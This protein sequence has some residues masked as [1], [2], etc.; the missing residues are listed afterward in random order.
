MKVYK[1]RSNALVNVSIEKYLIDWEKKV[2]A[3]Q[4][5]VKDLLFPFWKHEIVLEEFRIPGVGKLRVDLM[6]VSGQKVIIEISPRSSHSFNKFF[7][8]SREGGFLQAVK[9]DLDK[10][11]W[12]EKN[13]FIYCELRDNDLKNLS[14][15]LLK[16]DFGIIL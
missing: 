4:K 9:R 11:E 10:Q 3:P 7:H 14:V 2:S 1:N 6:K 12:A 16:N 5:K 13:G 8:G 15:D